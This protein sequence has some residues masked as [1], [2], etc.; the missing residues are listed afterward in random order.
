MSVLGHKNDYF[1]SYND[2]PSDFIEVRMLFASMPQPPNL[3]KGAM[4]A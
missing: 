4:G 2:F 3:G 1:L